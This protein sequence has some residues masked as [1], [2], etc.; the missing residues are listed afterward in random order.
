MH[1]QKKT[2]LILIQCARCRKW[3]VV[4]MDPEVLERHANGMLVQDAFANR[5]GVPYLEASL[6][7]LWISGA[8]GECW[9]LLCSPNRCDYQ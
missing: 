9:P 8:C 1:G 7:E 5:Q 3:Q 6:R 4:R 2:K